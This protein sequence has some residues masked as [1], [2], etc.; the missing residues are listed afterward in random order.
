MADRL[1][2]AAKDY[3]STFD[4]A[5]PPERYRKAEEELKA[6]VKECEQ[7]RAAASAGDECTGC[8]SA[9]IE[10]ILHIIRGKVAC[11]PDCST[12]T[13]SERNLIRD[14]ASLRATPGRCIC[15]PCD[16]SC[17]VHGAT[18]QLVYEYTQKGLHLNDGAEWPKRPIESKP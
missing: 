12:L 2:A 6:A 13:L 1:L 7:R 9:R 11:C 15:N 18:I 4:W 5:A 8:G 16:P 10:A 14:A 17:P 3:L